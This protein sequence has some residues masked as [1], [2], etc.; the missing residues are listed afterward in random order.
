MDP[1][2]ILYTE[3]QSTAILFYCFLQTII[4]H[5][6]RLILCLQQPGAI[7]N[8]TVKLGQSILIVL[9]RFHVG[10]GI[11]GVAPHYTPPPTTFNVLLDSYWF[12]NLGFLLRENLPLDASHLPLGVPNGRVLYRHKQQSFFWRRCREIKTRC[13]GSLHFQSLY[14]V[15]VLLY[16]TLF[17]V[18]ISILKKKKN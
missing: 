4:F 7:D 14:F 3:I 9:C 17:T 12:D 16:F 18:L 15:F 8:L 1:G 5:T 2:P 11:P 13:K 10:A 6:I